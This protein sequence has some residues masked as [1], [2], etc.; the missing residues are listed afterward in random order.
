M[1]LYSEP[2]EMAVLGALM[3]DP[4]QTRPVLAMLEPRHFAKQHHQVIFEAVQALAHEGVSVDIVTTRKQLTTMGKLDDIGG[5]AYLAQLMNDVPATTT[6][7]DYAKLVRDTWVKREFKARCEAGVK[8]AERN[9]STP[10]QLIA[11]AGELGEGLARASSATFDLYDEVS[12]DMAGEAEP[13]YG[14]S[15]GLKRLDSLTEDT[16][17]GGGFA[18]GEMSII[19]GPT[20]QGKTMLALNV[21]CEDIE[22][23]RRSAFVSFEMTRKQIVE[24]VMRMLCGYSTYERASNAGRADAFQAAFAKC[25]KASVLIYDSSVMERRPTVDDV[26]HWLEGHEREQ[27]LDKVY[28][29]YVQKLRLPNRGRKALWEEHADIAEMFRALTKRYGWATVPVSQVNVVD[30]KV[31]LRGSMEWPEAA[32][33]IVAVMPPDTKKG[34]D[35]NERNLLVEK[36]RNGSTG[37]VMTVRINT[38]TLRMTEVGA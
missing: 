12:A 33:F 7:P 32:G 19:A 34:Q 22:R 35:R 27:H 36:N 25:A 23:E 4:S 29:D 21:L 20:G 15:T 17:I 37:G 10:D 24:R 9:E 26:V 38:Q 2:A 5:V 16:V 8:T 28:L 14:S 31:Q 30:G 13:M 18:K 1:S 3:I 6:A 11:M